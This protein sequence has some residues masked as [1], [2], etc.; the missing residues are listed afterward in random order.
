MIPTPK[1]DH[2]SFKDYDRFYEPSEDTFLLLDTLQE[3]RDFILNHLKPLVCVELGYV[4]HPNN[5]PLLTYI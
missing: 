2:F 3:E 1:L 4:Y 5:N